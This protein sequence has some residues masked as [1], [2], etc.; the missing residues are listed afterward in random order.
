MI[1][2][3]RQDDIQCPRLVESVEIVGLPQL[4]LPVS[5][6]L[7][8]SQRPEADPPDYQMPLRRNP[9]RAIETYLRLCTSKTNSLCLHLMFLIVRTSDIDLVVLQNRFFTFFW[10]V[11]GSLLSPRDRP[12]SNSFD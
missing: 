1:L 2:S 6:S 11:S 5:V 9:S 10:S 4:D 7:R 3:D 8:V 12:T